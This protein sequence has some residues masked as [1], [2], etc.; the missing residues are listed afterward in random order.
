MTVRNKE[1]NDEL[2][3]LTDQ[4]RGKSSAPIVDQAI[5]VKKDSRPNTSASL[6]NRYTF[7]TANQA[8]QPKGIL[9]NKNDTSNNKK[10]AFHESP[11]KSED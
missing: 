4:L 5:T 6:Q 1:M 3:V 7:S 10:S 2:K 11:Y 9:K 8:E